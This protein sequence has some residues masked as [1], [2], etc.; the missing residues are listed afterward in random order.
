MDSPGEAVLPPR[1]VRSG[2]KLVLVASLAFTLAGCSASR[3]FEDKNEGGWFSKPLDVFAKPDWERSDS[4]SKTAEL[5]P[6]GPVGAEDLVGPDGRCT[7]ATPEAAQ[8]AVPAAIQPAGQAAGN[9]PDA[10]MAV[11]ANPPD[12]VQLQPGL[13][14]VLGGIALGMTEC[15][16][17]ARAGQPGH[18]AIGAGEKGQ[19]STVLTY[20]TG[21]WPGIYH[22]SDGRL[23]AV[24]R[25][26]A[27][28]EPPKAQPKKKSKKPVKKKGA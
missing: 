13:P 4:I 26:P 20:L 8:A 5:G 12:G 11:A 25:A 6:S 10:P 18:V 14:P 1:H 24:D 17:V 9:P 27:P 7:A 3:I 28:P 2:I 19:R 21:T 23:K 15:Q 16:A 22:F